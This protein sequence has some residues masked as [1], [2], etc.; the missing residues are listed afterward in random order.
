[1]IKPEDA[2]VDDG[3]VQQE[4]R[5]ILETVLHRRLAQ[6]ENVTRSTEPAWDSLQHVEIL[7]AV[8]GAC[9][10]RFDEDEMGQL[11]SLDLLVESVERH[12][13]T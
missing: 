7:L 4:V 10:V 1:M 9:D 3:Q 13:A 2:D 6:G 8:E 11:D 5:Q 12:R